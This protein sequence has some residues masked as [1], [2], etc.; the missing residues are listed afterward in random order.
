[1]GRLVASERSL[2]GN[3][4]MEKGKSVGSFIYYVVMTHT[5]HS[6]E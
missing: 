5:C 2:S 1:M 4:F 3:L 6:I